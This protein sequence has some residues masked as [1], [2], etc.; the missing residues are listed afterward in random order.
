[1]SKSLELFGDDS[2]EITIFDP[3]NV[4][5]VL[6]TYDNYHKAAPRVGITVKQLKAACISKKRVYAPN[7]K[8][9]VAIRITASVL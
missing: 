2:T 6:A 4:G 3:F 7:F 9:V 5:T 1:M 8:Q